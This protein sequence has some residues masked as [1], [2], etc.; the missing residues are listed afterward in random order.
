[1]FLKVS[2][3]ANNRV[4]LLDV[5]AAILV[6]QN[7]KTAAVLVSQTNSVGVEFFSYANVFLCFNKFL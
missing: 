2:I 4:S 5:K 1:M 6:C 7:N 3:S